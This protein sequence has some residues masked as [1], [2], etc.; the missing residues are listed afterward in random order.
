VIP[1]RSRAIAALLGL[2]AIVLGSVGV[3]RH[4][5]VET[6]AQ[7]EH[8]GEVHVQRVSDVAPQHQAGGAPTLADPVWWETEGDHHCGA[9][10]PIVAATPDILAVLVPAPVG[11]EHDPIV[12]SR[13]AVA[14]ALFRL[15]PK[16]SP[17]SA[18]V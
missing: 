2:L 6:H 5:T 9:A 10:A 4:V 15:A 13:V 14:A 3:N 11:A 1:L 18:S 7:C 8:G 12:V 17:P 16:T